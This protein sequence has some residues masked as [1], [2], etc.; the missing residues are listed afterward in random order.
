[1]DAAT[2]GF[3][4]E[5][6]LKRLDELFEEA[7][8]T[9]AGMTDTEETFP[10]PTDRATLESDR[11]FMLRIR[12]RERKLISKIREAIDRI[13]DG[14]FGVCESC[15]DDIGIE[16]LKARPVT[17]LCIDCKRKQE[18]SEKARGS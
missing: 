7:E 4:K 12:D 15:G 3:F 13:E 6:L 18:A 17:T 9:V 11:N 5:L 14:E 8:K 10:D 1:M 16:R 2:Q